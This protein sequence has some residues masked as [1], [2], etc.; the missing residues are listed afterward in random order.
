MV[1]MVIIAVNVNSN[2]GKAVDGRFKPSPPAVTFCR[3]KV[4]RLLC[5]DFM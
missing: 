4:Q 5:P 1:F 2:F 3:F